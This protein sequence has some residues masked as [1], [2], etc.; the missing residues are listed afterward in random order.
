MS[1]SALLPGELPEPVRDSTVAVPDALDAL[2]HGGWPEDLG[3]TT[4]QAQ[5]HRRDYID[6]VINIDVGRLDGEPRRDPLRLQALLRSL[7]RHIATG[8]SFATIVKT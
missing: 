5:R 2:V 1:P 8:A 7:A 3:A 6:D 4:S